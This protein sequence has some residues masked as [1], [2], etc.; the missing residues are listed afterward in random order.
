MISVN[1]LTCMNINSHFLENIFC[2][3]ARFSA[4]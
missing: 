4:S 2:S 3:L 1:G